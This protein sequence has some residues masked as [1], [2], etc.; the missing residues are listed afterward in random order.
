MQMDINRL[1]DQQRIKDVYNLDVNKIM[2]HAGILLLQAVEMISNYH[3]YIC[4]AAF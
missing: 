1:V 4:L 3:K 2:A